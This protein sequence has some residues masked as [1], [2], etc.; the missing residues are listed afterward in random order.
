MKINSQIKVPRP[1]RESSKD[2]YDDSYDK[3]L[4]RHFGGSDGKHLD[5]YQE[6][7]DTHEENDF[8][9]DGDGGSSDHSEEKSTSKNKKHD[10]DETY[11]IDHDW[12]HQGKDDYER[13]K[14]LSEKQV[15]E[16]QKNPGN[17][18][19]YEKDGMICS[20]C[21]DPETGDTSESCNYASKPYDRKL[22]YLTKKSH[23]QKHKV[24]IE[25][26]EPA[27]HEEESEDD[28]ERPIN[29][30][31]RGPKPLK[32]I[33]S[34]S[35]DADY[36]GYKLAGYNDDVDDYESGQKFARLKVEPKKQQ[37]PTKL[38]KENQNHDF[39]IIPTS[40]FKSKNL[41]QA[42]SDFK[43]K[44]WSKCEKLTKG[45]MTCYNCR[46]EKGMKQE[47]CMFI[48]ESNPN[49]YRVEHREGGSYNDDSRRRK[50]K[51]Q[52]TPT[53]TSTSLPRTTRGL[54][55]VKREKFARIRMGRPLMP[56]KLPKATAEP[57]VTP[58]PLDYD[59]AISSNKKAI[60]RTVNISKKIK[61]NMPFS[62]FGYGEFFN[63]FNNDRDHDDDA[64]ATTFVSFVK[65]AEN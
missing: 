53:T 31:P 47:E 6:Y 9:D 64:R 34:E 12:F 20:T 3:F 14:A 59:H 54:Q 18:K 48:Q 17:C 65:H 15:S 40:D 45:D 4:S 35:E 8:N 19:H 52:L 46:D 43:S 25:I 55:A 24:P 16:L 57:L 27:N 38:K 42:F 5:K 51:T 2:P 23:N 50:P 39:E 41:N 36:G 22:A 1:K 49:N 32:S 28:E 37:Q 58:N 62:D 44:D 56:T 29:P 63:D 26:E 30:P 21:E 60:K 10:D 11:G 7:K 61:R 13:I 33:H